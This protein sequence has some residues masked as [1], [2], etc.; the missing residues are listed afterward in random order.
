[1]HYFN[2]G[3]LIYKL[4][5]QGS[6]GSVS[7]KMHGG[8]T[9]PVTEAAAVHTNTHPHPHQG[10]ENTGEVGLSKPRR[11][12]PSSLRPQPQTHHEASCMEKTG[13]CS[14]SSSI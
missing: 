2:R 7:K 4:G 3:N 8:D 14:L 13:F 12:G 1:M 10:W 11:S 9:E 6:E 5:R